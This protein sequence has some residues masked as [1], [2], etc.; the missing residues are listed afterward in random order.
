[1]KHV[2]L[3]FQ[4]TNSA[5]ELETETMWTIPRDEGFEIDN[6]PFYVTELACGDI[7]SAEKDSEG[8]LWYSKLI[9]PSGHST[10][11]LW[12]AKEEDVPRVRDELKKLGCDSEGSDLR[13]LVAVD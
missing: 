6:I 7:V 9:R 3:R 2:K 8:L 4:F 1:M 12:F 13:R 10:I 11:Q 5:D